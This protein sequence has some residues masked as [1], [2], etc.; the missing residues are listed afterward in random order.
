MTAMVRDAAPGWLAQVPLWGVNALLLFW[1]VTTSGA[2]FPLL[3]LG[4]NG[5]A[6]DETARGDL[7][8]LLLPSLLMAPLLALARFRDVLALLLRNPLLLMLL[9]W[10]A[11]STVWSMAPDVTGRRVIGLLVNTAIAAFLVVDRDIDRILRLLS[12]T[13]L[14]L[15]IASAAFIAF[16]PDLGT[17][18]DGRGLRGAFVHKNLMGETVVIALIV[19]FAALRVGAISRGV[20]IVGYGLALALLLPVGAASSIVV[21]CLILAAQLFLLV[22]RWSFQQRLVILAF[23]LAFVIITAGIL[24]ANLDPVLGLL[25]RDATLTGRTDVWAFV[26]EMSADRPLLGFGYACFFEVERFARYVVE[27]FGWAIPTAHNGYLE[28]LLG[29]GWIGLG[30]FMLFLANMISRLITGW[31][32]FP[33]ALRIFVLPTLVFYAALNLTESTMLASSGLSWIVM[34]IAAFLLTPGLSTAAREPIANRDQA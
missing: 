26:L 23:G 4:A 28:I 14:I 24:F 30:L 3:A 15:L 2:I 18:P 16:L 31:R 8:L 25:G 17:M 22:D 5:L 29:L 6:L 9:V 1:L 19:F 20:G 10:V 27:G 33:P 11:A 12:W 32:R 34:V 7:R 21:G 13:L